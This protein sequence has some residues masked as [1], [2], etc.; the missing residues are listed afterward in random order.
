MLQTGLSLK[1]R[2]SLFLDLA[3]TKKF[4]F[5][6]KFEPTSLLIQHVKGNLIHQYM[7]EKREVSNVTQFMK[8]LV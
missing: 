6:Q 2:L 5:F 7:S 4:N 1:T 8:L 3:M